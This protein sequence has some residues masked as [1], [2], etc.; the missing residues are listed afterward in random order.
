MGELYRVCG[1]NLT[2]NLTI[3]RKIIELYTLSTELSTENG[4]LRPIHRKMHRTPFTTIH[5][6][7][8]IRHL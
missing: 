3:F 4:R 8:I 1:L 5:N 7:G 6:L 2:I